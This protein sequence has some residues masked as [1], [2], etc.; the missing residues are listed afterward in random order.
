MI[1]KKEFLVFLMAFFAITQLSAQ[2]ITH[3]AQGEKIVIYTDGS[4]RH[5][6]PSDSIYID[7]TTQD[8]SQTTNAN[9]TT[10]ASSINEIKALQEQLRLA[11]EER[12]K[13]EIEAQ[14]RREA[15]AR[16]KAL[17]EEQLGIERARIEKIENEKAAIEA[18]ARKEQEERAQI[19]MDKMKA[20]Q[21]KLR[22]EQKLKEKAEK[23]E[24]KRLDKI[25]RD[26]RKQAEKIQKEK[27][28]KKKK[29]KDELDKKAKD[30]RK[31]VE[32]RLK[33]EQ[34]QIRKAKKEKEQ[35]LKNLQKEK[36]RLE[37]EIRKENERKLK[38]EQENASDN[39]ALIN[40]SEKDLIRHNDDN[41]PTDILTQT[42]QPTTDTIEKVAPLTF[43]QKMK[44]IAELR[45]N[46]AL[47]AKFERDR[48]GNA[49]AKKIYVEQELKKAKD[50]SISVGEDEIKR[51]E[52][53]LSKAK[54][55][56]KA[57]KKRSNN[58][59]KKASKAIDASHKSPADQLAWYDKE[60]KDK[61]KALAKMNENKNDKSGKDG[62]S[63][64]SE[65]G[66]SNKNR[67]GKLAAYVNPAIHP[68]KADCNAESSIDES[69]GK[70][71]RDT[72]LKTLLEHT[73]ARMRPHLKGESYI[74]CLANLTTTAG[75]TF[76]NMKLSI[77]NE[78]ANI[79]FGGLPKNS[80]IQFMFIDGSTMT[81][82]KRRADD[83][84]VDQ[85]NKTTT[86]FIQLN[87]DKASEKTLKHKL[88]DKMK[89]FWGKGYE[90]Y[91][92]SNVDFFNKQV[93][94][95]RDGK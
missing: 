69:T 58:A 34:D 49:Q 39:K 23:D 40:R 57:A 92:I 45:K 21:D 66:N 63:K 61:N 64:R 26:K 38:L 46:Y 22:L 54:S 53:E 16:N 13:A 68:P 27:D 8:Q 59:S 36:E 7:S 6:Q 72:Y 43:N 62:L 11:R 18:Q 94:C 52:D 32:A 84:V 95:L 33:L 31:K 48:Y 55:E 30:E 76:I 78:K 75:Y 77:A 37:N 91:E 56:E 67:S 19:E 42:N 83:G 79:A 3:N 81:L 4:W 5:Y 86:Y 93:R 2:K 65:S 17:L 25:A 73:P 82:T 41:P 71:R 70:K 24:K 9:N 29:A 35:R 51:L 12:E 28:R 1:I 90:D 44:A 10:N 74:K 50:N 60:I 47:K 88:L 85:L 20:L 87:I 80:Q 14:E 89:I 15:E